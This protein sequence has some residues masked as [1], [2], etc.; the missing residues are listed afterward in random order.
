MHFQRSIVVL[1][2]LA[3]TASAQQQLR[4]DVSPHGPQLG[5][6][7]TQYI[8]FGIEIT[9]KGG[10]VNGLIGTVPVPMDWPEQQIRIA[11]E[12]QDDEVRKVTYRKLGDTVNQM[13]VELPRLGAGKTAKVLVTYEVRRHAMTAPKNTDNLKIP[14]K[15]GRDLRIYLGPSPYIESTHSKIRSLAKKIVEEK[16]DA[17]DWQKVEAIY[18]WVR[19]NIK[20]TNGTLKSSYQALK[21]GTGDCEELTSLFIAMCRANKIPARMVWVPGHCYPEFYLEDAD[22]KGHWFPC[23]AAGTRAFGSMPEWRPILQK[24]DNFRDPDRRGKKLRYVST[25]L[26]GK[27]SRGDGSPS[28]KFIRKN[29]AAPRKEKPLF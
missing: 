2:L 28:V 21:D 12:E 25:H 10:P 27:K 20:Y 26:M 23:Q 9:A 24:G 22:G 13:R 14:A 11:D 17:S 16:K 8:Q 1:F 19:E 18:D 6:A 7:R 4:P 3:A 15:P 5:E 29:V